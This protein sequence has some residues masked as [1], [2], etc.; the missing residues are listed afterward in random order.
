[1]EVTRWVYHRQGGGEPI[2]ARALVTQVGLCTVRHE[3]TPFLG[4]TLL[5]YLVC[6]SLDTK[7]FSGMS[8]HWQNHLGNTQ[9]HNRQIRAVN[10]TGVKGKLVILFSSSWE[11]KHKTPHR[12]MSP[13]RLKALIWNLKYS[14]WIHKSLFGLCL[15]LKGI[16]VG[17]QQT[18]VQK[19]SLK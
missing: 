5:G 2:A 8:C 12:A 14:I 18:G 16:S 10:Y 19:L 6:C 9:W 4:W 1:M 11:K 3:V 17:F 7:A 15:F 13:C